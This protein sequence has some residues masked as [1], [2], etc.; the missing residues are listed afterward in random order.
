MLVS[1]FNIKHLLLSFLKIITRLYPSKPEVR[2]PTLTIQIQ[3]QKKVKK[4]TDYIQI[5]QQKLKYLF[6]LSK[7]LFAILYFF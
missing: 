6:I 4:Y 1:I 5:R 7:L 2:Q 3:K